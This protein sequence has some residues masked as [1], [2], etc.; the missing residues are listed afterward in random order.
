MTSAGT[1]IGTVAAGDGG[2]AALVNHAGADDCY[3]EGGVHQIG[4]L[5]REWV[6]RQHDEIGKTVGLD[7]AGLEP[8]QA[9]SVDREK[10]EGLVDGERFGGCELDAVEGGGGN[11]GRNRDERLGGGDRGRSGGD[12]SYSS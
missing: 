3:I 9:R 7:G 1:Q 10:R 12:T 8:G 11:R 6:A 4:E 5:E 2:T